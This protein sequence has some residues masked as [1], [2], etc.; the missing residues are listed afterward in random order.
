MEKFQLETVANGWSAKS[1]RIFC[2]TKLVTPTCGST[3]P[4]ANGF[5]HEPP[6]GGVNGIG[7]GAPRTTPLVVNKPVPKSV[8]AAFRP[9]LGALKIAPAARITVFELT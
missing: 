9:M 3:S 4:A 5:D 6:T 8:A 7:F 1:T 2:P